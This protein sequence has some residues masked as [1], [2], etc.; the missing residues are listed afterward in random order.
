VIRVFKKKILSSLQREYYIFYRIKYE[1]DKCL[2][3]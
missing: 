2:N 3:T 1:K